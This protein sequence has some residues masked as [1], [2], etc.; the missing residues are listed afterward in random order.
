MSIKHILRE[1]K[2]RVTPE[3]IAIYEFLETKHLFTYNDIV[4]NFSTISRASVFRTL[5]LFLEL[6]VIRKLEVWENIATYE[7]QTTHHHHEHMKCSKCSTIINFESESICKKLFI[8]AKKMWFEIKS[9][10][11]GILGICKNCN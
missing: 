5:N 4:D 2:N 11:I 9:H 3:R 7:L 10:S 1:Q 6:W 8:E